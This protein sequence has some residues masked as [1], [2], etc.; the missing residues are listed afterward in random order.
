MWFKYYKG[1]YDV[2]KLELELE[3]V[4]VSCCVRSVLR[5]AA[6]S[7]RLTVYTRLPRYAIKLEIRD[8]FIEN[9]IFNIS[10]HVIYF[11]RFCSNIL[12]ETVLSRHHFNSI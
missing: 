6:I 7:N 10:L 5:K 8:F 11:K 2:R 1:Y 4:S 3:L 12:F 9:T